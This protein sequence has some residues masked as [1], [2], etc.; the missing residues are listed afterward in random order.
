MKPLRKNLLGSRG[1]RLLLSALILALALALCLPLFP[2]LV[3][4]NGRT[5]E[6]LLL[7][8]LREGETIALCYTHSVNLTPVTDTLRV[9]GGS[10]VLESTLFSAYGW[11]MPVLA[12]G[13]GGSF[14][15]TPEGFLLSDIDKK[16]DSIP[17]LLQEVPD[18]RLLY[19]GGER[20]LLE[21]APAGTFVRLGVERASLLDCL[22]GAG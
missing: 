1:R 14:E 8:P 10:L 9:S 13:I 20:R 7:L 12:D 18:Q 4:R 3:L 17:I 21:L 2:A 16:Q 15:N 11:G 22:L 5:G 6:R 19:R